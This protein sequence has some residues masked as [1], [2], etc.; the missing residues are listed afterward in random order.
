M[1]KWCA[2]PCYGVPTGDVDIATSDTFSGL[3]DEL[4]GRTSQ[5]LIKEMESDEGITIQIA[6]MED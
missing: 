6:Y 2:W 3:L 1:K 4:K 5:E